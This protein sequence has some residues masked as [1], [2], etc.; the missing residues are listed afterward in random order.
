M[1]RG[2]RGV[3]FILPIHILEWRGGIN[4]NTD[5]L[6]RGHVIGNRLGPNKLSDRRRGVSGCGHDVSGADP[7]GRVGQ[8]LLHLC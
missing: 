3:R 1:R 4:R 8:P 2:A 7:A 6:G 5:K